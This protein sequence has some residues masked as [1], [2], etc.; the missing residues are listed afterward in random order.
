MS[1][2]LTI[3]KEE[4]DTL[5][6]ST[7]NNIADMFEQLLLGNWVDDNGHN[8]QLNQQMVNLKGTVINIMEFRDKYLGYGGSKDV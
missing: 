6:R 4:L 3:P 1:K 7:G 5:L 8:V 2:E